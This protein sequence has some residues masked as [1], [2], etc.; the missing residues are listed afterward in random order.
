MTDTSHQPLLLTPAQ[1]AEVATRYLRLHTDA[2]DV[3]AWVGHPR[4]PLPHLIDGG[5][6]YVRPADLD[7]Y[8][9]QVVGPKLR[10]LTVPEAAARCASLGRPVTRR[11]VNYWITRGYPGPDGRRVRLPLAV[12]PD[13]P[14][15]RLIHPKALAAFVRKLPATYRPGR[16]R[17]SRTRKV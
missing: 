14:G 3:R 11:T 5:L 17:G 1:A 10:L 4:R 12:A 2:D 16:P 13:A 9:A 8:L 6:A 7:A 15:L